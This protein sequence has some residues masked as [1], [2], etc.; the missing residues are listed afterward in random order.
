MKEPMD[1]TMFFII[2]DLIFCCYEATLF[3]L[4]I[5]ITPLCNFIF[6]MFTRVTP[7]Y[8]KDIDGRRKNIDSSNRLT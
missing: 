2:S 5:S 4:L 7:L 1:V 8:K 6:D 3:L